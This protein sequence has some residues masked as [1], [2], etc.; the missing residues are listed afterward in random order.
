MLYNW[1][2][3]DWPHLRYD[4]TGIEDALLDFAGQIG[5]ITGVLKV[6]PDDVQM[7]AIIDTMVAEAIKTSVIEGESCV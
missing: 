7:D 1:Q 6:L 4:L 5:H 2:Q 3:Q